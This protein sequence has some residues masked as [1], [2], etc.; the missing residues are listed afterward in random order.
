MRWEFVGFWTLPVGH[1]PWMMS[2][3]QLPTPLALGAGRVRV[4]FGARTAAQRS[5]IGSVDLTIL[6]DGLREDDCPHEPVLAPGPD[7]HFDQHGVFPS[8]VVPSE[9]G[10]RLYYIGWTQGVES[11]MF[12][13]SI[14]LAESADGRQFTRVSPAPLMA[15]SIH[16]PCL[17]TSPHVYRH[18]DHWCMTYVSGVRWSRDGH[19]RLQSH[20][21]I[22]AATSLDGLQWQRTGRVAIDFG[23]GETNIARSTVWRA[24]PADHHMWFGYVHAAVGHYRLGYAHSIDGEEWVRRDELAGIG[25]DGVHA[26]TMQCYPAVFEMDGEVYLLWNGDGN[27]RAGFGVSRLRREP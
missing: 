22:K 27:G 23:V 25:L 13:A 19:G 24:G 2:H 3:A 20:Y 14:G 4:F 18:D 8:C 1:A 5:H 10:Y 26:R 16:D 6:A 15:R 21:H 17:V 9:T 11:P 7:G 12:D